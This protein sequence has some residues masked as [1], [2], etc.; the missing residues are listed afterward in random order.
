MSK[1]KEKDVWGQKTV[2]LDAIELT[3]I[4][5]GGGLKSSDERPSSKI[6]TG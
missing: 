1:R 3:A 4:I 6:N 5:I 2:M